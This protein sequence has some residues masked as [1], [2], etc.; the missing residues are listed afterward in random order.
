MAVEMRGVLEENA[1]KM[2]FLIWGKPTQALEN[3][4]KASN[5]N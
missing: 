2:S 3:K 5:R 4:Q 1:F